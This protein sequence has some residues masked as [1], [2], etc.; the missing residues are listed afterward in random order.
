MKKSL[1]KACRQIQYIQR[2]HIKTHSNVYVLVTRVS[3][4]N[5]ISYS[6]GDQKAIKTPKLNT[7]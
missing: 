7:N 4:E 5:S 1:Q 2:Y 3:N 6:F